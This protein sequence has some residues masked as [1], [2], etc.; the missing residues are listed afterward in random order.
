M[1]VETALESDLEEILA[2]QKL[3]YI[4]EAEICN[5]FSIPP[6]LQTIEEIKEEY[7][8]RVFLK[9]IN[10]GKIVGSVRAHMQDDTCYI[11]KLIVHPGFQNNGIGTTLL[12]EIENHFKTCKRYE[13]FTGRNS[14]RNFEFCVLGKIGHTDAARVSGRIPYIALWKVRAM[15]SSCCFLL[16]LIK[17]TA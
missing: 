13:L 4:S 17:L 15:T 11:G 6:L 16:S 10:D 7:R 9:V 8:N 1:I 3:A 5:D 12:R 2:L 14:V